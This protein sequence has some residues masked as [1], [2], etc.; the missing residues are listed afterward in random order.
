M[1]A[2]RF[3]LVVVAALI[4]GVVGVRPATATSALDVLDVLDVGAVELP[5]GLSSENIDHVATIP[6]DA[7]GVSAKVREVDDGRLL[8]M[9]GVRGLTIYDLGDPS[10]PVPLGHLPLPHSQNEDVQVSEDG[11][12]AIIAAD[13]NL[14]APSPVTRG[15]H[16]IDTTDPGNPRWQAWLDDAGRGTNHTAACADDAC[17]WIYGNRGLIY[18]VPADVESGDDIE[19]V[20]NWFD[21]DE[22]VTSS[23]A[24]NRSVHPDPATGEPVSLLVS[25]STPRL[26]IDAT[27]PAR[28]RLLATSDPAD[29]A[30]DGFLQHNNLR[31]NA[32]D[33]TPRSNRVTPPGKAKGRPEGT[34]RP[35]GKGGGDEGGAEGATDPFGGDLRP[36][37]LLIGNSESNVVPRCD[38]Q[39]GG[40]TTFSMADFD[41]GATIEPLH[42][43]RPTN[44]AYAG[45]GNPPANALGCSGHWFDIQDGDNL[46]A[47]SWYEHGV[48]VIE[49]LPDYSMRQIGFFQP[50]ATEAGAAQWVVDADGTEYIVSTDYARG[51]DILRFDRD[52]SKRAGDAE[53]SQAQTLAAG[54]VGT[55][56]Q[57]ER[58]YCS[59]ENL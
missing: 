18:H 20:G 30:G 16:I 27:D 17:E 43:F 49:V 13:G 52:P 50:V 22:R 11:T 38:D 58:Y 31:P 35:E 59:L 15:L 41:T 26:V 21:L 53:I 42:T 32:G 12:R 10:L 2:R 4:A 39:S 54:R 3:R 33:W 51:I 36:G 7:P 56:S 57:L 28:P 29:H 44:S 14:P 8:F 6:L 1:H 9:S 24:L 5:A 19:V 37:E 45:D 55:F 46:I 34:G 47:A 25:D 48:K 23:H 40:L